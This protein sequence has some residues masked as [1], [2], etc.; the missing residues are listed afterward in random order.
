[1][2]FD[3]RQVIHG[4]ELTKEEAII[5]CKAENILDEAW[6]KLDSVDNTEI[7]KDLIPTIDNARFALGECNARLNVR[8]TCERKE[9]KK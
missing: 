8:I 9:S 2:Q 1:M 6:R 4:I 7:D 3:F 5:L